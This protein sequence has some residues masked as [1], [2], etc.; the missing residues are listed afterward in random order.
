MNKASVYES[1]E[2]SKNKPAV[3]KQNAPERKREQVQDKVERR[4]AKS[5]NKLNKETERRKEMQK[6]IKSCIKEEKQRVEKLQNGIDDL[7]NQIGKKTEKIEAMKTQKKTQKKK[8][9][10]WKF[11]MDFGIAKSWLRRRELY[12][13]CDK[14][15][16]RKKKINKRIKKYER[17]IQCDLQV[18]NDKKS[19]PQR[20]TPSCFFAKGQVPPR[21][22][23]IHDHTDDNPRPS[24]YKQNQSHKV[25][26]TSRGKDELDDIR[27]IYVL[28]SDDDT[29]S[30]NGSI[31]NSISS[32]SDEEKEVKMKSKPKCPNT[33]HA[34][35]ATWIL[36]Q[37]TL[38]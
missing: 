12:G 35:E 29:H 21:Q 4:L 26:H 13:K 20:P 15:L 31:A 17:K 25:L 34:K 19:A 10:W 2:K 24:D 7:K 22:V 30:S 1:L 36:N 28:D 9:S 23:E 18:M 32:E 6:T 16:I 37:L 11:D 3:K 14:R 5:E 27:N 38:S 8:K 33:F